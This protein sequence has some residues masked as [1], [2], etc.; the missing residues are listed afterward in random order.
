MGAIFFVSVALMNGGG[1]AVQ[2][3]YVGGIPMGGQTKNTAQTLI[4][5]AVNQYKKVR[6]EIQANPGSAVVRATTTEIGIEFNQDILLQRTFAYGRD[7]SFFTNMFQQ[8]RALLVGKNIAM[9]VSVD[10]ASY[11]NFTSTILTA[12][13][14]PAQNASFFFSTQSAD[15]EF[16]PATMGVV[17]DTKYLQKTLSERA[18]N[19]SLEK[20]SLRQKPDTPI[21]YMEGADQARERARNFILKGPYILHAQD[22]SWEIETDDLIEWITFV[23]EKAEAGYQ[24]AAVISQEKIEEYLA[25]FAPGLNTPP[26]NAEFAMQDG[27][28]TAFTLSE[29]GQEL[30]AGVSARA[31]KN[32]I[33]NG[34]NRTSL[35]FNSV[36]PTITIE[37]INNLGITDL[38]GRGESDFA[39]SPKNR[40]HNIQI[41]ANKFHG[42]IVAPNEEFSFNALLG[43]VSA[44]EGYLPE[45][46][47]KKDK[48][49]PEYGGGLCQVST[50]IFRAALDAGLKI[51]ARANH[52]FP[53][54]YYGTPG[55]DA[56]IYPPSPDL[57]FRNN[58]PS[59]LL[60]QYKIDGTKLMFEIYGS[61]DG[62]ETELIGP[63]TYDKKED[64]SLKAWVKQV[65]RNQ[66]GGVIE[67]HTFYS[68]YKSPALY[69]IERNPLE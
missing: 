40:A 65:V 67:E 45:L 50:T 24:L 52:A 47:I 48:T 56:T 59:H 21:V 20:I 57:K 60:L 43:E 41:G 9:A 42:V 11:K 31:I 35:T 66:E 53:V 36:E 22:K 58:T 29:S 15:W 55:L 62:R 49:I 68:N 12:I 5:N 3:L 4:E 34:A 33:E 13:H 37:K 26:I 39:G 25:R 23:P 10:E 7:G 61:D 2:G 63:V 6:I 14:R 51:T 54:R 30:A 28:A 69:P 64:G 18:E 44:A 19:L 46:V 17:V 38:L 8:A 32:M 16:V 27:R 1:F